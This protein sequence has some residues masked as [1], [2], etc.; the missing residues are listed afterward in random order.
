MVLWI[1][2]RKL[3]DLYDIVLKDIREW[4]AMALA[5]GQAVLGRVMEQQRL[6]STVDYGLA[7]GK[8]RTIGKRL[9]EISHKQAV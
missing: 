3:K 6:N 7:E 9:E 4:A 8:K 2:L 1:E 5:D